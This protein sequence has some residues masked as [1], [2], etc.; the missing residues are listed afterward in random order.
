MFTSLHIEN[1]RGIREAQIQDFKLLNLFWGENDC[2]KTTVLESLFLLSG[3]SNP[4]LPMS[5][6][7]FRGFP[8]LTEGDIRYLFFGLNESLPIKLE[9]KNENVRVLT[10]T[11]IHSD[12]PSAN[13]QDMN[14]SNPPQRFF[15]LSLDYDYNGIRYHSELHMVDGEGGSVPDYVRDGAEGYVET[16]HTRFM[17]SGINFNNIISLLKT[18]IA[19]NDKAFILEALKQ[20]DIRVAGWD[21]IDNTVMVDIG[22]GSL[23]PINIM[24]NGIRKLLSIMATI[25]S[26]ENGMA[27][28]DEIDNGVHFAHFYDIWKSIKWAAEKYN[29]QVFATTHSIDCLK[30][31][32][33][34]LN[35]ESS[36]D[37]KENGRGFVLKAKEDGLLESFSFS[38][39]QLKYAFA[40]DFDLR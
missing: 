14:Q 17:Y 19:N 33:R 32:S 5:N 37:S 29:V 7:T 16:L 40:N 3:P 11:P 9:A 39:Y 22:L 20:F 28:I 24:G 35:L 18:I 6:N 27:F 8:G 15:G 21:I 23:V 13:E 25:Y 26:C 34:V 1:Y 10:I 12:A 2:G 30:G 4:R 38:K 36:S 31:F